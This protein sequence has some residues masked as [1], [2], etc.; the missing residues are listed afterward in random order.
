MSA[1]DP[2][3]PSEQG[4]R[5][6]SDWVDDAACVGQ[7]MHPEFGGDQAR[8]LAVCKPCTVK[9]QCLAAGWGDEYGIWGGTTPAQRRALLRKRALPTRQGA[10]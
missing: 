8:M 5:V 7:D 1:H 9:T 3:T 6:R 2:S 4:R 10:A